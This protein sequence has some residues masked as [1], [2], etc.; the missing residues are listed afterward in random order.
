M[1]PRTLELPPPVLPSHAPW[2]FSPSPGRSPFAP[3]GMSICGESA[4]ANIY[5]TFRTD[6]RFRATTLIITRPAADV[7]L[8]RWLSLT[9]VLPACALPSLRCC[10]MLVV[11]H[12]CHVGHDAMR[13]EQHR[14]R[15][16]KKKEE[17]GEEAAHGHNKQS[18]QCNQCTHQWRQ[19]H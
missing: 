8:A 19:T 9:S 2:W 18:N 11:L 14:R 6:A 5:I 13:C 15:K 1:S 3:P 4:R 17:G 10:C 16:R 7:A 12:M